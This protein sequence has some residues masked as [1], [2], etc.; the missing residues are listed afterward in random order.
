MR[1]STSGFTIVEIVTVIVIIGIL[2][3]ITLVLYSQS[4]KSSRDN[5][6]RV[7]VKSIMTA[8]QSYYNDNGEYPVCPAGANNECSAKTLL[9]PK[10]VPKYIN[11]IPD[12]PN[13]GGYSYIRGT[14][15]DSYGIQVKNEATPV[16]KAGVNI[17]N[18]W[19]G[20]TTPICP[21]I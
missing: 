2:A 12:Q 5:T 9:T 11:E 19:W 20:T 1:K 18:S 16:C 10:L 7:Q 3:S 15:L 14:Q 13:G 8:L 21:D 6:R 17:V 4:Q